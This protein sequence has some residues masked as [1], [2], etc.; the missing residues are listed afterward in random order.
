MKA[1]VT[2]LLASGQA[3][4]VQRQELLSII[5]E[6]CDRLNHLVEEAAEMARLEAGEVE[7]HFTAVPVS[8]IVQQT[9]THLRTALA[10]RTVNVRVRNALP[11]VRADLE[12][13]VDV[14]MKL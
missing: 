7:L 11:P 5:N 2:G 12:R 8:E 3:D 9:L 13:I 10:G 1:A 6:E 14:L 4:T